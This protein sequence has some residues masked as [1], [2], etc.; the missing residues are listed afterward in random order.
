MATT[1]HTSGAQADPS[2]PFFVPGGVDFEKLP[3]ELQAAIRGVID[4]AYRRL[5]LGARDGLEKSVGVTVVHL[6]WLE[7]LDQFDLADDLDGML[8]PA[9]SE[10]RRRSIERH[11][12]VVGAKTKASQFLLR[13]HEF[14]RKWGLGFEPPG[15]SPES[16]DPP[17]GWPDNQQPGNQ[18]R[19]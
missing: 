19:G 4:P 14:R 16:T 6:L 1:P 9:V 17:G 15:S 10:E 7:L 12:R 2:R 8:R 18:L 11:L 13:L 5:V 3:E